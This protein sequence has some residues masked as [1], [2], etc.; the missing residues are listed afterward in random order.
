METVPLLST[1]G[2]P[3]VAAFTLILY[4]LGVEGFCDWSAGLRMDQGEKY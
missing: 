3:V 2:V 4:R 1:V